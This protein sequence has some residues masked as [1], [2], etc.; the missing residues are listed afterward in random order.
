M[1]VAVSHHAYI[2]SLDA[3]A[4]ERAWKAWLSRALTA[5]TVSRS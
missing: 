4:T 5:A 1:P 2:D 3:E